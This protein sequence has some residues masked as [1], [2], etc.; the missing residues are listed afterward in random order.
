MIGC[1]R[2]SNKE[3][4]KTCKLTYSKGKSFECRYIVKKLR[5]WWTLGESSSSIKAF[6]LNKRECFFYL[7][8]K[9]KKEGIREE[10]DEAMMKRILF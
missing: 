2:S 3:E 9:L 4:D 5:P 7:V 6:S 10:N 8:F 1:V